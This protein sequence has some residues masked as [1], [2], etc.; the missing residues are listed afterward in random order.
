MTEADFATLVT[1]TGLAEG[2]KL[3]AYQDTVGVW[4][5]GFGTN[6]QELAI[7]QCTANKWLRDKLTACDVE[8]AR[9]FPWYAGATAARQRAVSELLYNLGLPRL[10]GFVKFL[11]AMSRGDFVS[12]S[13]ELLNSKWASQVGVTRS[14]RIANTILHG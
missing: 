4:T 7:D 14:M 9:A 1:D 11:A 8:A 2:C 12:A 10:Q 3:V 13:A 5:V 6:L